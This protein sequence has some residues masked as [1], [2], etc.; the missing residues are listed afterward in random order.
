[1]YWKETCSPHKPPGRKRRAVP[2]RMFA[3]ECLMVISLS[4]SYFSCSAASNTV[5]T[6]FLEHLLQET[7]KK[8]YSFGFPPTSLFP[9]SLL[10]WLL[11]A[12]PISTPELSLLFIL[13][14]ILSSLI[15][16]CGCRFHLNHDVTQK[17][18]LRFH[19]SSCPPETLSV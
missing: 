3:T 9:L 19:H 2:P 6:S 5:T 15:W 18:Y 4:L 10:S 7:S 11:H 8:L 16:S 1:M 14:H 13:L 12:S 17:L